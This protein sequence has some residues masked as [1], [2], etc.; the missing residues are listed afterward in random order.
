MGRRF[1]T[2]E[3]ALGFE[4]QPVLAERYPLVIPADRHFKGVKPL[5]IGIHDDV[6]SEN[7]E[8]DPVAL[9]AFFMRLATSVHYLRACEKDGSERFG[10]DGVANGVV[11]PD[12]SRL[13]GIRLERKRARQKERAL[14]GKPEARTA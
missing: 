4:I 11:T 8:L 6:L 13:A 3:M 7:P 10:L 9:S 2:E 12:Q 1:T 14:A 5:K